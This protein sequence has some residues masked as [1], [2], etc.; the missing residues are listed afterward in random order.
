VGVEAC[1]LQVLEHPSDGGLRWKGLPLLQPQRAQ[2][3]AGQ[4]GGVLPYRRQAPG[5]GQ[6]PGDGQGQDRGQ[7]SSARPIAEVGH[8]P[9]N[10][11][12]GLARQGGRGGGWHQRGL[13][14]R[15][16]D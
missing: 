11:G 12:Q 14:G 16:D 5:T 9:E 3:C 1:G 2:V 10:L 6:N 15:G 8:V 4:V 13:P 7:A